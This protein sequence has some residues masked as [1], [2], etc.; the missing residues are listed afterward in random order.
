[1][2]I[3]VGFH[4]ID[5]FAQFVQIANGVA[6]AIGIKKLP[7]GFG[8]DVELID[9]HVAS[10]PIQSLEIIQGS[11]AVFGRRRSASADA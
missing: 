11:S 2:E 5:R 10:V 3:L 7:N 4:P 1:L 6:V 9:G 8:H